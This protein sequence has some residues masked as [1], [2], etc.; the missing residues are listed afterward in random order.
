[1]KYNAYK[2]I[3]ALVLI[4]T[5]AFFAVS[6]INGMVGLFDS[7]SATAASAASA[8]MDNDVMLNIITYIFAVASS[9]VASGA[10]IFAVR[11]RIFC[12]EDEYN[13]FMWKYRTRNWHTYEIRGGHRGQIT[14]MIICDKL[15]VTVKAPNIQSAYQYAH[16][17]FRGNGIVAFSVTEVADSNNY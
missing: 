8:R 11:N 4:A 3:R 10:I 6:A 1:M 9:L 2:K 15:L 17:H 5:I 16:S 7:V 12:S 13:A 14:N